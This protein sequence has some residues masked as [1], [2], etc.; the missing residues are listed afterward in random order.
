M[1]APAEDAVQCV[2]CHARDS[3]LTGLN[4]FYL[5]GRDSHF[6]IELFG[7]LAVVGGLLGVI[8]HSAVRYLTARKRKNLQ[9][10]GGDHE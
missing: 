5:I 9:T 3:R 10:S 4:D 1:V 6:W 2:A 7:L 8:G